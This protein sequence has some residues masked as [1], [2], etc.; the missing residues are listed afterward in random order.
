[1]DVQAL[2]KD[3]VAKEAQIS[4]LKTDLLKIQQAA[5]EQTREL[6][7][8]EEYISRLK[9]ALK[10]RASDLKVDE[11]VLF[12]ILNS[13][14]ER[15][16]VANLEIENQQLRIKN[17]TCKQLITEITNATKIA[18]DALAERQEEVKHLRAQLLE[19][20]SQKN[21]NELLLAEIRQLTERKDQLE[22]KIHRL[23]E[24]N[25]TAVQ[26]NNSLQAVQNDFL[27]EHGQLKDKY[28]ELLRWREEHD[29]ASL[30][31]KTETAY[32]GSTR[33]ESCD[34]SIQIS[35]LPSA[36]SA[37]S[38][39]QDIISSTLNVEQ[40]DVSSSGAPSY[41]V[42]LDKSQ[43]ISSLVERIVLNN[44]FGEGSKTLDA[45]CQTCIGLYKERDKLRAE[46]N[47]LNDELTWI[48]GQ[49]SEER[50]KVNEQAEKISA[51][52]MENTNLNTRFG[53][54]IDSMTILLKDMAPKYQQ[55]VD[56]IIEISKNV[57]NFNDGCTD[58]QKILKICD[59]IISSEIPEVMSA[60]LQSMYATAREKDGIDVRETPAILRAHNND[61]NN[62][63]GY[64]T[65]EPGLVLSSPTV[66]A[67]KPE[68]KILD[69]VNALL[70]QSL[71][72]DY[73]FGSYA[74]D[75]DLMNVD[76]KL[77]ELHRF[78]DVHS[79]HLNS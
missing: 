35:P 62:G 79:L 78:L 30:S 38:D 76:Q 4:S 21:S 23:L 37:P 66:A 58:E 34:K 77:K 69:K 51:L 5:A 74:G 26:L 22:E 32:S 11:R 29:S 20:H 61:E 16:Q 65:D 27:V 24:E 52:E 46:I 39:H 41:G 14:K 45:T 53:N 44:D 49:L 13:C 18:R 17:A 47:R 72:Y 31:L 71:T 56:L 12:T 33:I 55:M 48:N 50:H 25:A 2:R 70:E 43:T 57:I 9:M 7:F 42:G 60:E 64:H 63:D 8:Q 40:L 10:T 6:K 3:I 59:L 1:M 68:G 36:P 54:E 19:M 75:A 73:S 67:D 15:K 28:E